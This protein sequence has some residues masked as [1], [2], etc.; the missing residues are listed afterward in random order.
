MTEDESEKTIRQLLLGAQEKLDTVLKIQRDTTTDRLKDRRAIQRH[1]KRIEHLE[2]QVARLS[3]TSPNVQSWRPN[4]AYL[5][6]DE[7]D[8]ID[9]D[10][11]DD[12]VLD[13]SEP[14]G[15]D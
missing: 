15:K 11:L 7:Y 6:T 1:G 4:P 9:L 13:D 10:E 12:G 3:N 5:E 2:M 8:A 14:S